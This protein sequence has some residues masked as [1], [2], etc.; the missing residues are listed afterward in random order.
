VAARHGETSS[1]RVTLESTT[2]HI[3]SSDRPH[4]GS[5]TPRELY[6]SEPAGDGSPYYG[7]E[8]RDREPEGEGEGEGEGDGDAGSGWQERHGGSAA[9]VELR[10]SLPPDECTSLGSALGI[11]GLTLSAPRPPEDAAA[12]HTSTHS[13]YV[14]APLRQPLGQR[15]VVLRCPLPASAASCASSASLLGQVEVTLQHPGGGGAGVSGS[16]GSSGKEGDGGA[17]GGGHSEGD[18]A[19]FS[20]S[21]GVPSEEEVTAAAKEEERDCDSE[22]D[23]QEPNK[24]R[25]RHASKSSPPYFLVFLRVFLT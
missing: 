17:G 18:P 2:L 1:P 3:V 19:S 21:F 22:G 6:I 11:E 10:L 20:V 25:A 8:V 9:V 13:L 23:P 14:P 12:T 4:P 5:A 16:V 7:V 24:H 15:G